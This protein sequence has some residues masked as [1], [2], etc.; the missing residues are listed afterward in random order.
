[1]IEIYISNI[2]RNIREIT[3]A[4]G[5][6]EGSV[7]ASRG[8]GEP[9]TFISPDDRPL[10]TAGGPGIPRTYVC[11]HHIRASFQLTGRGI[12]FQLKFG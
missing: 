7:A 10:A 6:G 9:A 12:Y 3:L 1:M 11:S 5:L 4:A 8:W 2:Y